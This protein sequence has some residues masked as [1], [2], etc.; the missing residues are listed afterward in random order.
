M[1]FTLAGG[2]RTTN[3]YSLFPCHRCGKGPVRDNQGQIKSGQPEILLATLGPLNRSC[4]SRPLPQKT[5]SDFDFQSRKLNR[6]KFSAKRLLLR[7]ASHGTRFHQAPSHADV[8]TG[9]SARRYRSFPLSASACCSR[10]GRRASSIQQERNG[11][12]E[13]HEKKVSF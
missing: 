4:R 2:D 9:R 3:S 5:R 8:V 12:P 6:K 10:I 7:M 11:Y 1:I 13:H